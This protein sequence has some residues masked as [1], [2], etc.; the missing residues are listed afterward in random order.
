MIEHFWKCVMLFF[1]I[2]ALENELFYLHFQLLLTEGKQ[3]IFYCKNIE[4]QHM[5]DIFMFW[6]TITHL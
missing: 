2:F 5:L 1:Y 3:F 6:T 4:K